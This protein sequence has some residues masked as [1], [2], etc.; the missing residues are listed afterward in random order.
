MADVLPVAY[1]DRF[2]QAILNLPMKGKDD[3]YERMDL[4]QPHFQL[5]SEADLDVYYAPFHHLNAGARVVLMG[6]TPGW[7]QMEAAFRAARQGL[8]QGLE[9]QSLF[10]RIQ[11][12]GSFSGPLRKNL[13]AMLDE[14]SLNA[15]LGIASCLD[16]FN[17]S[18]H[19]AH[20]TSAVEVPIFRRGENYR[21]Y[22]PPLLGVSALKRWIVENLAMELAS[23]PEAVIIPL[24][25][26]ADEVIQFLHERNLISLD[27]CLAG[28]PHPSGANGHRKEDFQRG[29][30][31]WSEQL[32]GWFAA[33]Q[34]GR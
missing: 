34:E 12:T 6:L 33:S 13:V 1:F 30:G 15:Q 23:I 16:L 14:I 21:G 25:R 7:T 17:A 11:K 27:R 9:G 5:F 8:A 32:S 29:R 4:L 26:V 31:R 24:G 20:F 2:R 10:E 19:L 22:G 18:S 28:F 3:K